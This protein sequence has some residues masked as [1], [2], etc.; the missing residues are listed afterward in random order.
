[1]VTVIVSDETVLLAT[2]YQRSVLLPEST[3]AFLTEN[4]PRVEPLI[5][6][7]ALPLEIKSTTIIQLATEVVR[8]KLK[9]L[10]ELP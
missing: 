3:L 2:M 6:A 4:A 8:L 5:E 9:L 1:M 7:A 10:P